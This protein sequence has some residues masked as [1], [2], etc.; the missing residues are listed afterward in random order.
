M[1]SEICSSRQKEGNGTQGG[2]RTFGQIGDDD[3]LPEPVPGDLSERRNSF[4]SCTGAS[5]SPWS[6]NKVLT[7][8]MQSAR[9]GSVMSERLRG[10]G[11][12]ITE[13][14]IFR[15]NPSGLE[16][17]EAHLEAI[18]QDY[19]ETEAKRRGVLFSTVNWRNVVGGAGRPQDIVNKELE[20]AHYLLLILWDRWGTPTGTEDSPGYSSGTMEEFAKA[21]ELLRDENKPMLQIAVFFREVDPIR[22][23]DAG[24]QLQ[25]VV[26]FKTLIESSK[27][28]L[29]TTFSAP[30]DFESK[31]RAYLSRWLRDCEEGRELVARDLPRLQ[32]LVKS[33]SG[34][35]TSKV[36]MKPELSTMEEPRIRFSPIKPHDS[37]SINGLKA[38]RRKLRRNA[39]AA[40]VILTVF[41]LL[42]TKPFWNVPE[43]EIVPMV[44]LIS[45]SQVRGS[46]NEHPTISVPHNNQFVIFIIS[47][48]KLPNFEEFEIVL[49]TRTR[50]I[51]KKG[52]IRREDLDSLNLS[53]HRSF[54]ADGDASF[55]LYSTEN[56]ARMLVAEFPFKVTNE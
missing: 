56:Q 29:Y 2:L 30:A 23:K 39:T 16:D 46:Y 52:G 34:D 12:R 48:Y 9:V 20:Q 21:I 26:D 17:I 18:V 13:R 25:Q 42:W 8:S 41:A 14:R 10:L 45:Q 28:I 6:Q 4:L 1:S 11:R 15:S 36:R 3:A 40:A 31:L 5:S 53:V 55:R 37:D 51:W 49:Y 44:N 47:L 35:H 54:L 33:F 43:P 27:E 50:A 19:N 7:K 24:P 38:T 32:V 22:L